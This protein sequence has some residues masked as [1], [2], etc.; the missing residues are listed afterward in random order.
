[1]RDRPDLLHKLGMLGG[2]GVA[3]G[4]MLQ[5]SA[6]EQAAREEKETMRSRELADAVVRFQKLKVIQEM[7]ERGE[8]VEPNPEDAFNDGMPEPG[9][10]GE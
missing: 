10:S 3:V 2:G 8:Y 9:S 6:T 5:Q 4:G 1:M 7:K